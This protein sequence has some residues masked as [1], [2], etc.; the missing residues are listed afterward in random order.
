MNPYNCANK[1]LLFVNLW[2]Q[3]PTL[4]NLINLKRRRFNWFGFW[5]N[6]IVHY[7]CL[8]W[9]NGFL[10]LS[11]GWEFVILRRKNLSNVFDEKGKVDMM[12]L[13]LTDYAL[14]NRVTGK[15]DQQIQ[16]KAIAVNHPRGSLGTKIWIIIFFFFSSFQLW[17]IFF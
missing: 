14:W 4:R 1:W 12:F 3:K 15:L 9:L 7:K 16:I 2:G 13:I 6:K 5:K 17:K 10:T 11:V 8:G